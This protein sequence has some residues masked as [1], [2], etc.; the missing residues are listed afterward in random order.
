[1]AR[2]RVKQVGQR[3]RL[4]Q[5]CDV[6]LEDVHERHSPVRKTVNAKPKLPAPAHLDRN[7]N[8]SQHCLELPLEEV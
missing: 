2:A 1:M 4:A 8:N 7:R 6:L 5:A 3:V